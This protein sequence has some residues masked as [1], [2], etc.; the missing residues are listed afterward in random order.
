MANRKFEAQTIFA[1]RLEVHTDTAFDG[2]TVDFKRALS[3]LC[4]HSCQTLH[5]ID[6]LSI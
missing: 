4:T 3:K 6:S 2:D 1:V 5:M